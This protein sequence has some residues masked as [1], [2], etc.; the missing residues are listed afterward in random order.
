MSRRRTSSRP[1]SST[2]GFIQ[3]SMSD[4]NMVEKGANYNSAYSGSNDSSDQSVIE[5]KD[6]A[7]AGD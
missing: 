6:G 5:P 1:F 4:V 2:S 3:S 7:I